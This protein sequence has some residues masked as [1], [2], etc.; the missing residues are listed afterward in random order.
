[1][2]R[3]SDSIWNALSNIFAGA[4]AQR[5]RNTSHVHRR[6]LRFEHCE[7]RRMLAT[8]FVDS[9]TD[10]DTGTTLREAVAFAAQSADTEDFVKFDETVFEDGG[11]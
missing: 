3:K 5:R 8:Y 7:D 2:E 1:M 4:R 10:N 9:T 11:L 6:R